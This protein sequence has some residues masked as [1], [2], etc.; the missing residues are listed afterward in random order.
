[1]SCVAQI[2]N[3]IVPSYALRFIVPSYADPDVDE[4]NESMIVNYYDSNDD[5][6]TKYFAVE[7]NKAF[8]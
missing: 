1:M 2:L 8:Q 6:G 5:I 4:G 3:L 7:D